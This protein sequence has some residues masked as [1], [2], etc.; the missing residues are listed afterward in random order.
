MAANF[1]HIMQQLVC[2]CASLPEIRA[3]RVSF[4]TGLFYDQ[5][6]LSG[7]GYWVI[8]DWILPTVNRLLRVKFASL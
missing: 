2:V 3:A 1:L 7:G 6:F 4:E 5:Y 8:V